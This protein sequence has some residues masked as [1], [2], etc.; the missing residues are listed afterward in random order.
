M[1]KIPHTVPVTFTINE[2]LDAG[3]DLGTPVVDRYQSP[4]TFAGKI[5]KVVVEIR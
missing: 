4:F 1:E 3:R 2:G 5:Q